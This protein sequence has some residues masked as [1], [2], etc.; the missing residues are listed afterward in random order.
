MNYRT[1]FLIFLSAAM[2]FV[3]LSCESAASERIKPISR[4]EMIYYSNEKNSNDKNSRKDNKPTSAP[5]L[6]M[7]KIGD[8]W[9]VSLNE[10]PSTGFLWTMTVKGNETA[11]ITEYYTEG[12]NDESIVGKPG[13]RTWKIKA[14]KTGML[15]LHFIYSRPWDKD[16]IQNKIDLYYSISN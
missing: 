16:N 9:S 10:N 11:E 5:V 3:V 13:I 6:E 14:I 1:A 8:E 15:E 2:M 4:E 12:E 7:K